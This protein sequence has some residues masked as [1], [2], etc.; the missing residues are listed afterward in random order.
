MLLTFAA[1][2]NIEWY[3]IGN[4]EQIIDFDYKP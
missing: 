1:N 4:K 3:V 2:N